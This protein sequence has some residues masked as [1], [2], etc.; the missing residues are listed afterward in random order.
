MVKRICLLAGILITALIPAVWIQISDTAD[1]GPLVRAE[2][3][4][5]GD[6]TAEEY[7]LSGQSLTVMEGEQEL[8]QSPEDWSVDHFVIGDADNDGTDNL[9]VSLWKTGSFG[10]IRPFWMTEEDNGYKNHLF[11]YNLE[12]DTFQSVW[13]SSELDCPIVSYEIRDADGDG[14]NELVVQE[15]EYRKIDGER[16]DLDSDAPV[17]TT[18]WQ[19]EEWGFSLVISS[20][21]TNKQYNS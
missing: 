10:E 21:N 13:C 15:G 7:L 19:W 17:R 16:Y 14:L 11:L 20:G 1:A 5:D 8:W 2:A 18:V 6:G 9:T 4:L 3:D 12:G